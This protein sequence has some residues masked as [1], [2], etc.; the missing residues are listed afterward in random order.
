MEVFLNFEYNSTAP[1][2]SDLGTPMIAK[3]FQ[4][5]VVAKAGSFQ[6]FANY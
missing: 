5:A 6:V 4:T 1:V 2:E 3:L